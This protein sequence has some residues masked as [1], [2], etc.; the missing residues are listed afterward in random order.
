MKLIFVRKRCTNRQ[1]GV[2]KKWQALYILAGR[3]LKSAQS[4]KHLSSEMHTLNALIESWNVTATVISYM[5]AL[6]SKCEMTTLNRLRV[7]YNKVMR[8]LLGLH[9]WCSAST[10]FRRYYNMCRF[11]YIIV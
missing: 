7:T 3:R 1:N 4:K 5:A 10:M 8:R 6:W 2:K 9:P 11:V